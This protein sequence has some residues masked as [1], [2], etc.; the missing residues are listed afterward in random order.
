MQEFFGIRKFRKILKI[1]E[2]KKSLRVFEDENNIYRAGD[3]V[4]NAPLPYTTKFPVLLPKHHHITELVV[5]KDHEIVNHN[6]IRETLT[7]TRSEYWIP[8]GRQLVK[9]LLK[10]CVTCKK[11]Q[12]KSYVSP[13]SPPLPSYRV[14]DKPAFTH[15]GVDFAG[16]LLVKNIYETTPT[17][18]N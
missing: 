16:P 13:D 18:D 14:S 6:G 2:T 9:S 5:R 11:L 4:E 7:Q 3:R 12:G 8:K 1:E 17:S 15:I 10:K